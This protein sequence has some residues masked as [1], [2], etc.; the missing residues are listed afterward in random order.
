MKVRR[1]SAVFM[2]A[3]SLVPWGLARGR[4]PD[5]TNSTHSNSTNSN[6][7]APS[8]QTTEPQGYYGSP[9]NPNTAINPGDNNPSVRPGTPG[10][11]TTGAT[12]T[13]GSNASPGTTGVGGTTGTSGTAGP[14]GGVGSPGGSG[15]AASR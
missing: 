10:T 8:G 11:G 7:N 9:V 2:A 4:A 13:T 5:T 15:G 12:G 1:W 6:P 14:N 3:M